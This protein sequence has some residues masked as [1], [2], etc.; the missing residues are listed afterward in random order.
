MTVTQVQK[1]VENL[2]MTITT[3]LDASVSRAWQMWEDPRQ[4]EQWWGPPT[5][6]ATFLEHDLTPG[7][8]ASYFMTGPEGEQ[9]RGWWRILAVEAPNRL[10]FEDGFA[11]DSGKPDP[12][13]PISIIGVQL[14]EQSD[15]VTR[16]T[17]E[18]RFSSIASMEKLI[19]MGMQEGMVAAV[20]QLDDL[21]KDL[22]AQQ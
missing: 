8:L 4:L 18:T 13:M 2:T 21:L 20:G 15:R 10:E 14:A 17:I 11:D 22:S 3:E 19:A 7:A 5:Y 9:F 16:M 12:A 1:D 6:P